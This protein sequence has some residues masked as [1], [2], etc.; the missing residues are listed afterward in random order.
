[1]H[2]NEDLVHSVVNYIALQINFNSTKFCSEV[3]FNKHARADIILMNEE[4]KTGLI[5]ELKY[6]SS[7]DEVIEQTQKYL[8]KFKHNKKIK[9]NQ[10]HKNKYQARQN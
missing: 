2:G 6:K 3:W 1:V 9:K 10:I 5:I 8:G 7:A 4:K